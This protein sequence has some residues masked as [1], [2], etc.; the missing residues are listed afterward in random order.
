M[1]RRRVGSLRRARATVRAGYDAPILK[2]LVPQTGQMPWVAGRPFFI[3][4]AFGSLISRE[5]LHLTQ[6]PVA[7]GHLHARILNT[8][9]RT[10]T[11]PS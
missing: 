7:T 2:I 9:P 1:V 8:T 3:V 5:A 10:G 11:H 6:Y 4:I